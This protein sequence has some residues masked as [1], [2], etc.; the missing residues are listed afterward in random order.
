MSKLVKRIYYAVRLKL[1]T[2]LCISNGENE[3]TDCDV[4]RTWDGEPFIPGTSFAGAVRT[5]CE[6]TN[7]GDQTLFGSSEDNGKMSRIWLSDFY[8]DSEVSST[9]RDGVALKD[10]IAVKGAK[11]DYEILEHGSGILYM[12]LYLWDDDKEEIA[13]DTVQKI[14]SAIH[15]GEIRLGAQKNRGL[16]KL[17]VEKVYQWEFSKEN[18]K[19]WIDYTK[20]KLTEDSHLVKF[21]EWDSSC[22]R[23]ITVTVP[24]KLT[25]GLSI[26]QYS[27]KVKEPDFVSLMRKTDVKEECPAIPGSSW[28]GAIRSRMEQILVDLGMEKELHAKCLE[29][30]G[31]VLE[32]EKIAKASEMVV[33]EGVLT[34]NRFIRVTR[35]RISR[36]ENA[37][38]LKNLYQERC[39]VE[40]TTELEIKVAVRLEQRDWF[41]G[42]L[43]LA[44]KDLQKGYLAI[45]GGTA[46]GHGIFEENG[47][48]KISSE[49]KE[50][51][52]IQALREKISEVKHG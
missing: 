40:G 46:I 14:I 50:E 8:F 9:I 44:I 2:P 27:T 51:Y 12:Q 32:K 36:F 11:Y 29:A 42:L 20:E 35:N 41:I 30:W 4:I 52:Y 34:G 25:G 23:Y 18:V 15:L 45:G 17:R 22:S 10:K 49:E 26:R 13:T 19:K 47:E 48:V 21:E 31:Y 3:L 16:G 7:I 38:V 43:L 39:A 6:E 24:L 1:E 33:S 28:K 5:F 37:A